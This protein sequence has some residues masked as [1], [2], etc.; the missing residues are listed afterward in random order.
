MGMAS[1]LMLAAS[2][3]SLIMPAI[4]FCNAQNKTAAIIV[5]FG[6]LIGGTIIE[7]T[8]LIL[9][10]SKKYSDESK[11]SILM[12]GAVIAHNIPEGFAVGVAFASSA[13]VNGNLIG[14][15]MFTLGIGIQNFPEGMCISLPM[16]AQGTSKFKAFFVGQASGLVEI[17]AGVLGAIMVA[18]ISNLLPWALAMSA[19]A[20]VAV[21][22]SEIIPSC[23]CYNKMFSTSGILI[24][25]ALMTVLDLAL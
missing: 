10:K 24:G 6:F 25:F 23:Y 2:F 1:G 4:E 11:R 5:T 9:C 15:I 22:C 12:S 16:K 3:F 21:V 14:A 17:A 20:M 18:F 7:F 19:G 8:D 13:L